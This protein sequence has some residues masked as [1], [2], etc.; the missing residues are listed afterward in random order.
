[1]RLIVAL[2]MVELLFGT[3]RSAAA[4]PGKPSAPSVQEDSSAAS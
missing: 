2:T 3:A 4:D 1:M